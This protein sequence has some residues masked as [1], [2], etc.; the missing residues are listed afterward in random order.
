MD[1]SRPVQGYNH[2]VKILCYIV[3]AFFEKKPSAQQRQPHAFRSQQPT[4]FWQLRVHE[5]FP[6]RKDYPANSQPAN[7]LQ[8]GFYFSNTNFLLVARL[9]DVTH[10]APAVTG[11]VRV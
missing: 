3:G 4:N 6:A 8:L 1:F 9:P 11:T 10:D 2:V 5:R 7:G